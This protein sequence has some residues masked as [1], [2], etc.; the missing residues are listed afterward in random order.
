KALL[1]MTGEPPLLEA[2]ERRDEGLLQK[3]TQWN[4]LNLPLVAIGEIERFGRTASLRQR[5]DAALDAIWNWS[6]RNVPS[7]LRYRR[8]FPM[9]KPAYN[10]LVANFQQGAGLKLEEARLAADLMI[11]DVIDRA[12]EN[13]SNFHTDK[14]PPLAPFASYTPRFSP[15]PQPGELERGRKLA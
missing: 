2:D 10:E 14:A 15:A 1:E 5:H 12:A 4:L 6:E 8:V 9:I 7:K 11:M 3:E 13:L